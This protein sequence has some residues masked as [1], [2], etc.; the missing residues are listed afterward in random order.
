MPGYA[1]QPKLDKPILIVEPDTLDE[2]YDN[3]F[4]G[5]KYNPI[6]AEVIIEVI[7]EGEPIKLPESQVYRTYEYAH[8]F[9]SPKQI[10]FTWDQSKGT[11]LLME[12]I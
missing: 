3:T 4:Y 10:N 9:A 6:T 8:W 2:L 7:Q 11:N 12:V 1:I 5:L